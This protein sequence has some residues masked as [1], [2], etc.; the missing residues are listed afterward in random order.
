[1][2]VVVITLWYTRS[3]KTWAHGGNEAETYSGRPL[4][5]QTS[6]HLQ[7]EFHSSWHTVRGSGR[8]GDEDTWLVAGT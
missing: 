5:G 6:E 7:E 8:C 4:P 1:M 2:A 3:F